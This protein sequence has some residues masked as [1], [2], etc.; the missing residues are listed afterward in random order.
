SVEHLY[1]DS[2]FLRAYNE[3]IQE[4]FSSCVEALPAGRTLRVL[5]VGAGTGGTTVHVLSRL[6]A[7]RTDYLFTDVS[8]LFLARAGEKL[9]EHSFV[10]YQV[11]DVERGPE[12]QGLAPGSVDV[13]LAANVLHATADLKESLRNV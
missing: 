2:P 9:R 13:V 5:E 11:L 4:V 10:R 1:Q 8:P 7:H 3:L 6:P 12:G